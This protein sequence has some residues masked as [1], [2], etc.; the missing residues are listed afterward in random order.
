MWF[1]RNKAA[2]TR[3]DTGRRGERAAER[4][5][6]REGYRLLGRNVHVPVGEADLVFESPDARTIVL[7]EVKA[8]AVTPGDAP[9][10]PERAITRHKAKKL[11]AVA[12]SIIR[13]NNW[14]DRPVRIDVIA[15][16][17]NKDGRQPAAVRHYPGA[18][19]AAGGRV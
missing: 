11:V 9:R 7:V 13:Q 18:I 8:R 4:H 19:D 6:R 3:S 1:S 12:R 2:P 15:V 17:F 5:L 16:E 14:Q 10:T